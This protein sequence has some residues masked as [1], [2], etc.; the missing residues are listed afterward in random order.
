M[1]ANLTVGKKGY[2]TAWASSSAL[3][4]RGQ[5]LK[6]QLLAA[7]DDDTRAFDDVLAAMRLPKASEDEKRARADAI[8]VAYEKATSV[9]L[10][11]ARLCLAAIELALEAALT[12]NRNSASD[13]GVGALIAKAGLEAAILNVRIN[14]PSVREGTFKSATIAEIADLQSKSA[15][16]LAKT[17]AAVEASLKS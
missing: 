2:E 16:P 14:L 5:A 9:P 6:A 13:A 15:G 17:L 12:G 1:V 4:E 10:A 8:A 11:T 7:V 3:A